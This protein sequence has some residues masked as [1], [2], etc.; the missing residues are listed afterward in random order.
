VISDFHENQ[1][2]GFRP[3]AFQSKKVKGSNFHDYLKVFLVPT[4]LLKLG[5][6]YY[7]MH[8]ARYP[9]EGY[10]WGL[11]GFIIASLANFGLFLWKTR[12]DEN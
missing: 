10:G 4:F 7:G 5:I 1:H 6:L 11:F 2:W 9:G 8:Y 3:E 12:N